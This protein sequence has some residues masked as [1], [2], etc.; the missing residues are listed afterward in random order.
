MRKLKSCGVLVMR[1][2]PQ[3]SFLL[4]RYPD[5]YDLPKGHIEFGE[6]ELTCALRELYEETGIKA[7]DIELDQG[8]RFVDKYQTKYKRFP[9]EVI[10]KTLV[11]FLGWLKQEVNLK[12]DGHITYSWI[13]W[14]PPHNIQ[15][16]TINPLLEKL[17]LYLN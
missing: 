5:R 2:Q 16:R 7:Q 11:I 6:D 9:G 1:S 3:M 8:F 12:L 15:D 4:L 10:D 14:N 17:H 13:E